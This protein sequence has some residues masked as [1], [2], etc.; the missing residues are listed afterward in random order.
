MSEAR[1]N[2]NRFSSRKEEESYMIYKYHPEYVGNITGS[3]YEQVY[4]FSYE[5]P[6]RQNE[7]INPRLL[8]KKIVN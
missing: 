3:A 4:L 6:F 8:R 5:N 1:Q 7:V 2:P